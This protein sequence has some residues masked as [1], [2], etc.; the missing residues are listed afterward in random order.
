MFDNWLWPNKK[1]FDHEWS[2]ENMVF[3]FSSAYNKKELEDSWRDIL[4]E[5]LKKVSSVQVITIDMLNPRIPDYYSAES[6]DK[7]ESQIAY[8]RPVKDVFGLVQRYDHNLPLFMP[9]LV[10]EKGILK[11]ISGRT[12]M[13]VAF[14]IGETVKG[15]VIDKDKLN[16]YILGP[17]GRKSFKE[18]GS[19]F[20]KNQESIDGVLDYL[21]G[22]VSKKY[23]QSMEEFDGRD[24][25][26]FDYMI[27]LTKRQLK[28][29][30]IKGRYMLERL[31]P[32]K[33]KEFDWKEYSS[34]SQSFIY[35]EKSGYPQWNV[36]L[37]EVS[38][39]TFL[40]VYG[41]G[42]KIIG[43]KAF[44]AFDKAVDFAESKFTELTSFNKDVKVV[45]IRDKKKPVS[46]FHQKPIKSKVLSI[47]T[48]K[49]T[50]ILDENYIRGIDG[51]DY[52]QYKD[53]M[54]DEVWR[55]DAKT[56]LILQKQNE[57]DR[58]EYQDYLDGILKTNPRQK[59]KTYK[60]WVEFHKKNILAK[61]NPSK[62]IHRELIGAASSLEQINDMIDNKWNYSKNILTPVGEN[63]WSV[64]VMTRVHP[65]GSH[66]FPKD[67]IDGGLKV[68]DGVRV[69]CK[70][71]RYRFERVIK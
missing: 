43:E 17:I 27:D 33:K 10:N 34:L 18:H 63:E 38:E 64:S 53:E 8:M 13:S 6:L 20:A 57:K 61:R 49:L 69:V 36:K 67:M 70:G 59:P 1:E 62:K 48:K 56:D 32:R 50:E 41:D 28:M 65:N 24:Q 54:Q 45:D 71:G 47:P 31:N 19:L 68:I 23:L 66:G 4:F 40:V 55:R 58:E 52:E 7:L 51:K 9:I 60:E 37:Y 14:L 15:I 2:S 3:F 21:D 12:R 11:T 42:Y 22:K 25:K 5:N 29:N 26:E 30:P 39:N 16:K 46:K 35:L 44:K